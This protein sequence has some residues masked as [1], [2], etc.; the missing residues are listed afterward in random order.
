VSALEI[1]LRRG[2]GVAGPAA[3]RTVT[4]DSSRLSAA[5]RTS[6]DRAMTAAHVDSLPA[7]LAS[8]RAM[9]DRR[10]YELT[11]ETAAGTR[12]ILV[13]EPAAEEPLLDLFELIERLAAGSANDAA[14]DPGG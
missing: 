7:R 1:T 9:P 4:L 10:Q 14:A 3:T 8:P 5:D 13:D 6:L 11:I 2:G 12:T